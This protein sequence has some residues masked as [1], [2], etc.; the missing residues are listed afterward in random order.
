[1]T[2]IDDFVGLVNRELG[3]T[4]DV[5]DV[6]RNLDEV[7]GWDSVLLLTLLTA[8]ERET[9][10]PVPFAEVLEADNLARIYALATES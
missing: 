7:A 6:Q 10:R 1:M 9:G 8:L 3:L 2:S 4:V 5:D